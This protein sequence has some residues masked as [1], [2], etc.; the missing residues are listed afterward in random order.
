MKL[1]EIFEHLT[2]GELATLDLGGAASGGIQET[3]YPKVI[4]YINQGLIEL[5]KK[6]PF[7]TG[8]LELALSDDIFDYQLK[9]DYATNSASTQPVKYILDSLAVPFVDKI[10]L[11]T[12]VKNIAGIGL[13][14]NILERDT[15]VFTPEENVLRVPEAKTGEILTVGY[16]CYPA[17]LPLE[18]EDPSLVEVPVPYSFLEALGSYV[19]HRAYLALPSPEPENSSSYYNRFLSACAMAQNLGLNAEPT[20]QLTKFERDGFV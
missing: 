14:L 5:Y 11:V 7:K 9:P 19:A 6:F 4:S 1:S 18:P 13:P 12:S 3:D 8:S 17:T 20:H 2:F 15:A 16:R 10:L